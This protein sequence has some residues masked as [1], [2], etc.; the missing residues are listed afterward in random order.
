MNT[1]QQ[2]FEKSASL[3]KALNI[4]IV[5]EDRSRSWGGFLKRGNTGRAICKRVFS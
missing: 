3:L 4:D 2:V 1:S 5:K